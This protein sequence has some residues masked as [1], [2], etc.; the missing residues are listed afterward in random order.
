MLRKSSI[1]ITILIILSLALIACSSSSDSE[2]LMELSETEEEIYNKFA[3]DY[4]ESHLKGVKPLSICKLYLHAGQVQDYETEY[5]LFIQDENYLGWSK[6]EH[7]EIP[8]EHRQK[9][10]DMFEKTEDIQVSYSE[11]NQQ[12][13]I[14]WIVSDDSNKDA[15]G[16][17][18]RYSFSLAKNKEGIW[19][20]CF[21]PMQ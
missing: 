11:D 15:D 10:W 4:D 1:Y 3:Q 16:E 21:L 5:E 8:K 6:E 9:D 14:S 20:V 7:M 2:N 19:K 18:F 13:F 12:A 17:P